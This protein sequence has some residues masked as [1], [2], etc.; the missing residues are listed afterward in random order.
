MT[1]SRSRQEDRWLL[2][3][4]VALPW[5]SVRIGNISCPSL[6]EWQLWPR[7]ESQRGRPPSPWH[8]APTL[9]SSCGSPRRGWQEGSLG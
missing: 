9:P 7:W 3:F 2:I 5:P 1:T 8:P 4:P 6:K